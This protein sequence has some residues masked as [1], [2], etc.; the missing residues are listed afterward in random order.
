MQIM[1]LYFPS[2]FS[3]LEKQK[4]LG[5]LLQQVKQNY[6]VFSC[7]KQTNKTK[8]YGRN[9][10]EKFEVAKVQ[11]SV[12]ITSHCKIRAEDHLREM[13]VKHGQGSSLILTNRE[14]MKASFLGSSYFAVDGILL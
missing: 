1:S 11:I 9:K 4:N 6:C 10:K 5:L 3:N 12:G 14:E 8:P 2:K 7:S 13:M